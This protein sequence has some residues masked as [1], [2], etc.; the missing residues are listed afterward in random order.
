[1]ARTE[2]STIQ[3]VY[4][5]LHLPFLATGANENLIIDE[6]GFVKTGGS[7]GG[8]STSFEDIL[9]RPSDNA[10][11]NN[12]LL[13][14]KN[15]LSGVENDEVLFELYEIITTGV[16]GT[17]NIPNGGT[18]LLD[19]YEN[20][21]DAICA[22]VDNNNRPIPEPVYSATGTPVVVQ[23]FNIYGNW[24]LSTQPSAYPVAIIY[25][26]K[27]KQK[28]VDKVPLGSIVSSTVEGL[29]EHIADSTV[30]YLQ[31]NISI[32]ESQ[33]SDLKDYELKLPDTPSNPENKFLDGNRTWHEIAVGSGGYAANLY[34]TND[35][36][37]TDPEYLQL[38]Y[39][40]PMTPVE[41]IITVNNNEV[42]GSV[43]IFDKPLAVASIDSGI[44]TA[45]L[46]A[47]I[48]ST[49]GTTQ[50]RME[51]FCR[52]ADGVEYVLF[53]KT[54]EDISSTNYT[55][56]TIN[57]YNSVFNINSTDQLGV[58]IY[59][60]TNSQ[61]DIT[62][63]YIIGGGDATYF[64]TPLALRHMQ[65]RGL[66][67]NITYQ[68]VDAGHIGHIVATGT[69]LDYQNKI[70]MSVVGTP[71]GPNSTGNVGDVAYDGNYLYIW[72]AANKNMRIPAAAIY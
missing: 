66:N 71:A 5:A 8:T 31:E 2:K 51:V 35:M 9:G 23:S 62:I 69:G 70:F 7:G 24:H 12:E 26:I 11:L 38:S 50:L 41:K 42:L 63:S 59:G 16:T 6:A 34:L 72:Y 17:V 4:G 10:A 55:N 46:R 68:H 43:F 15:R 18:I 30:H 49:A 44:W 37:A 47:K 48:S 54:T 32:T 27:I 36:S 61:A 60:K 64:N 13:G 57:I 65:L 1:M 58:K 22:M 56:I 33:I 28:D 14:I 25:I 39:I 52:Q 29:E 20:A 40:C 3:L 19:R 53:D 45:K 21:G 67:D